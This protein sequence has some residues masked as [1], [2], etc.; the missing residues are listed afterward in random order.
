M[1]ESIIEDEELII[2]DDNGSELHPQP[3]DEVISGCDEENTDSA[4]SSQSLSTTETMIHTQSADSSVNPEKLLEVLNQVVVTIQN[5]ASSLTIQSVEDQYATALH[6][7]KNQQDHFQAARWFRK[8]AMRGHA[9]SQFYLGVLF[10]KGQGVPQ[11]LFHAYAWLTLA[12]KQNLP[13][14]DESLKKVEPHLS[15]KMIQQALKLAA[16]RFEQIEAAL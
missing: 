9:K 14:A 1:Q 8:A 3:M 5:Q 11:S 2:E 16:E 13:E 6:W 15:N 10:A 4:I 7:V 12:S